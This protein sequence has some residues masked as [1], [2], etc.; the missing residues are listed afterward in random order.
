MNPESTSATPAVTDAADQTDSQA[1]ATK[2]FTQDEV[3]AILAKTKSQLERKFSGR[4]E[5]LGDPDELREIVKS[6]R[7]QQ[8][9]LEVKKGNFE[10]VLQD[11]ASKKDDEIRK[12]DKIIEEFRVNSPILDAAARYRSVNPEQ[13]KQL[14]RGHVRLN[15]EGEVE[16]LDKNGQVRYDDSGRALSVDALVQEFLQA[17]PH[18]VQPT[19]TTS[20]TKSNTGKGIDAM[21]VTKLD[22]R[23]PEDRARYREFRKIA[24]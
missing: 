6:Y 18:F 1:Q 8:Q 24:G 13:V 3:N 2:T 17:N 19:P 22:M 4:Y 11:L 16:V 23:N 21:D 5:E 9:D 14:V 15:G 7:Q 20:A 12:R 10:K